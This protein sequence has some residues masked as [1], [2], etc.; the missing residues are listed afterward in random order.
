QDAVLRKLVGDDPTA[1]RPVGFDPTAPLLVGKDNATTA[2]RVALGRKLFFDTRLSKDG[3]AAC[4]T[5]HDVSRGFSDGRMASEGVGGQVGRR[6]SPTVM[7]AM[8][9]QV[10]FWD[11]RSN[12]LEDQARLPIVY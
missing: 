6:N 2:K 1:R 5:C 3:T 12:T 7:N 11:G 4:A 10:Q 9:F 8:F